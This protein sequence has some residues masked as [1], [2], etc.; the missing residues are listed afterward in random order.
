[1]VAA[2]VPAHAEKE[3]KANTDRTTPHSVDRL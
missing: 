2:R 3:W 1:M